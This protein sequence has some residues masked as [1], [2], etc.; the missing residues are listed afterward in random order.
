MLLHASLFQLIAQNASLPSAALLMLPIVAMATRRRTPARRKPLPRQSEAHLRKLLDALESFVVIEDAD[1]TICFMNKR[2]RDVF[3][4]KKGQKCYR[5]FINRATPCP[6]CPVREILHEG[7]KSFTYFT[8]LSRGRFYESTAAPYALDNGRMAIIEILSDITEKKKAEE[9]IRELTRTLKEM[10]EE[11]T[12]ELR[13]SEELYSALLDNA[14]VTVFTIDPEADR[15]LR[16]NRAAEELTGYS[17]KELLAMKNTAL[18]RRGAFDAICRV[19]VDSPGGSGRFN[20]VEILRRDGRCTTVDASANILSFKDKRIILLIY[21]D[22]T[23]RL[24]IENRMRQLVSVVEGIR[25]CVILTDTKRKVIYVNPAGLKM[26][27][28]REEEMLG[29]QSARFFEG[30]PGNPPDLAEVVKS[31]AKNGHWAGEALNRRKSG[32]VFPVYLHMSTIRNEKDELIGY[33]GISEDISLR[34]KMEEDLI[35]KE[36][37]SALGQLIAGIAHELNNPLTGVLGYAEILQQYDCAPELK[38][39]L[40]RLYKEAIRCQCLVKNLLTFARRSTPHK[41]FCDINEV[42]NNS[43]S[44]KTHQLTADHV[45]LVAALGAKIPMV[46]LDPHQ[47]QQVLLNI[48]NNAHFALL[49][50]RA[51]RRITIGSSFQDGW[52]RVRISNNG[53]HIPVDKIDKIFDPFFSTKEFGKGTG[54]GLS[55][56]MGIVKDHGGNIFAESAEGKE[57]AFTVE[58]PLHGQQP[59]R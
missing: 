19:L 49:E 16:A 43:L 47:M 37:L 33:A 24:L 27:G 8:E 26:L 35:Q 55:I 45:E 15:I 42:I 34:K 38:E 12:A 17:L 53:P 54:L 21:R 4:N 1:Y 31:E 6:V 23:S 29:Q 20:Y 51:L 48:L 57:T 14:P 39:D 10:V 41:D 2:L 22:I 5:A 9:T 25:A 7:K 36:K 30:I 52:V 46:H 3:G 44:L 11:K 58:I 59:P 40:Q 50:K 13:H 56:A 18:Y 28:Y 32:E